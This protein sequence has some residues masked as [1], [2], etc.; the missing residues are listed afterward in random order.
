MKIL[1]FSLCIFLQ[2][3]Q[4]VSPRGNKISLLTKFPR[5]DNADDDNVLNIFVCSDSKK[6]ELISELLG[7]GN[8]SGAAKFYAEALQMYEGYLD[9]I[10]RALKMINARESQ[11]LPAPT[12]PVDPLNA[13]NVK[14][15][16]DVFRNFCLALASQESTFG[17]REAGNFK[18]LSKFVFFVFLF[19]FFLIFFFILFRSV[20]CNKPCQAVEASECYG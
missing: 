3:Q 10:F 18:N 2:I 1:T 5:A 20:C 11:G 8:A 9:E 7:S 19:F 6:Q 12:S 16:L 15:L 17:L 4:I 14:R 13:S